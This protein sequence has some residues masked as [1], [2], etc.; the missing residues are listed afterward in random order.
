MCLAICHMVTISLWRSR[1]ESCPI[2]SH[3]Q[4]IESG[5]THVHNV[6]LYDHVQKSVLYSPWKLAPTHLWSARHHNLVN[7]ARACVA[8][9]ARPGLPTLV[10][11]ALNA[12]RG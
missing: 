6:L 12:L 5:N 4:D 9:F 10:P 8:F 7:S 2:M 11:A 1:V 3:A